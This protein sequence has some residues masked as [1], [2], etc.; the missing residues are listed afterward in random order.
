MVDHF[1]KIHRAE[2]WPQEWV[3]QHRLSQCEK[4][5][6][7]FGRLVS[8]SPKCFAEN[9]A[10]FLRN[11]FNL[12]DLL[13]APPLL[14]IRDGVLNILSVCYTPPQRVTFCCLLSRTSLPVASRTSP[15]AFFLLLDL[16][17]CLNKMATFVPSLLHKQF[18]ALPQKLF[19]CI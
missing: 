7:W 13:L 9:G 15:L 1:R 17:P 19:L 12:S 2:D 5:L 14:V 8:H 10:S 11:S 16:S 6:H 4:F 18:A 3:L